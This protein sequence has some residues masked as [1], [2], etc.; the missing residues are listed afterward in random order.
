M[1]PA[2]FRLERGRIYV[3]S[4]MRAIKRPLRIETPIATV[5][6]VGT[7]F[8]VTWL[9]EALRVHVREGLVTLHAADAH[10]SEHVAPGEILSFSEA[11]GFERTDGAAYGPS[12]AWVADVAPNL[13][14]QERR[15]EQV[16][17]WVC[18]ELGYRLRYADTRTKQAVDQV[19]LDGSLEGLSPEQ[20]LEVLR[21]I[22]TFRYQ[23][24]D[25]ELI[26]ESTHG[27]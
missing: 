22:T 9:E 3:D 15:L 14:P 16:L 8:Q 26:L 13:D 12:W 19:M 7:Q 27:G 4:G 10:D 18:R 5:R 20:T 21:N 17:M 11:H 24:N 2:E 6:D 23:Q 25:G 1:G